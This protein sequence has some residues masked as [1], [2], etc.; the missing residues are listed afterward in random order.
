MKV[1]TLIFLAKLVILHLHSVHCRIN[2]GF[3]YE[4][5]SAFV[6]YQSSALSSIKIVSVMGLFF[7]KQA[8]TVVSPIH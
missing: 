7:Y 3:Q 5:P 1:L 8:K 6:L 2:V 4:K